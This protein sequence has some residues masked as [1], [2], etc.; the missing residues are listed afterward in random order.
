MDYDRETT[1]GVDGEGLECSRVRLGGGRV[2]ERDVR[3]INEFVFV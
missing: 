2:F 1:M 3:V